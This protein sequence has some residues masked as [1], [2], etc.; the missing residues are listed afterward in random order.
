MNEVFPPN[1]PDI[2]KYP[3]GRFR[4]DDSLFLP[5]DLQLISETS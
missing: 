4:T 2:S 5:A 1:V 3:Q